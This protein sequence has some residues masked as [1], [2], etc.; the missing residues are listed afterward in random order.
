MIRTLNLCDSGI[1]N[2]NSAKAGGVI[3]ASF[4]MPELAANYGRKH[5]NTYTHIEE[6]E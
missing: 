5:S 4:I 6:N 3:H 1:Y 2:Y